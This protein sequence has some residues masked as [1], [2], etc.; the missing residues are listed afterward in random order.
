MSSAA[1]DGISVRTSRRVALP[2]P[3]QDVQKLRYPLEFLD[4]EINLPIVRSATPASS[5]SHPLKGEPCFRPSPLHRDMSHS[6]VIVKLRAAECEQKSCESERRLLG[7]RS[8]T[9]DVTDRCF[10]VATSDLHSAH[11]TTPYC[12]LTRRCPTRQQNSRPGR[13]QVFLSSQ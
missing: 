13:Q 4:T 7:I 9:L 5:F 3:G 10:L 2:P 11:R 6:A 8:S 12:S 1:R